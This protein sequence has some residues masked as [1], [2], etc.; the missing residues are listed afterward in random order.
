MDEQD[1]PATQNEE[2][3]GYSLYEFY[4]NTRN[5][6]EPETVSK[7]ERIDICFWNKLQDDCADV[8]DESGY[9]MRPD[10]RCRHAAVYSSRNDGMA[11]VLILN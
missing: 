6:K 3:E 8:F 11:I 9:A 1:N 7:P 4:L 2:D 5:T 10:R